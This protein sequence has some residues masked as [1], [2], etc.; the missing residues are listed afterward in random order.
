MLK[1]ESL[2]H[3]IV[4]KIAAVT[5]VYFIF[6]I[7]FLTVVLRIFERRMSFFALQVSEIGCDRGFLLPVIGKS[8]P[9]FEESVKRAYVLFSSKEVMIF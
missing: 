8:L 4:S 6:M 2:N 1:F 9:S 3:C 7:I 5:R